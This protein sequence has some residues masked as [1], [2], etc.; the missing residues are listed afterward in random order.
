MPGS[1]TVAASLYQSSRTKPRRACL[2]SQP[3]D[4]AVA[5]VVNG[6]RG[7]VRAVAA[8]DGVIVGRAQARFAPLGNGPLIAELLNAPL[9]AQLRYSGPADALWRLTGSEIIDM[10]GPLAVGA[11]IGGRTSPTR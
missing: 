9:F 10:T 8:S 7:A 1:R 11:D 2:A 4:L 5:A 6:N 3:I